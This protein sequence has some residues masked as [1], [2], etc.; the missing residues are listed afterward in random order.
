[1]SRMAWALCLALAAHFVFL[2]IPTPTEQPFSAPKETSRRISIQFSP[3]E[4]VSRRVAKKV[5]AKKPAEPQVTRTP[6]IRK[7][8]KLKTSLTLGAPTKKIRVQNKKSMS[9]PHPTP[10]TFVETTKSRQKDHPENRAT[11]Q[12]ETVSAAI[13]AKNIVQKDVKTGA[14]EKTPTPKIQMP[15]IPTETRPETAADNVVVPPAGTFEQAPK[16]T[17]IENPI[18]QASIPSEN[19]RI[20]AMQHPVYPRAARRQGREGI[21]QIRVEVLPDGTLGKLEIHVSSGSH[22]LDHSAIEAVEQW[23]FKPAT[24]G[25]KTVAQTAVFPIRFTLK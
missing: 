9:M 1:M 2:K 23:R 22:D 20:A 21:V 4:P 17:K 15:E 5:P 10:L 11:K 18:L 7:P 25:G 3:A 16:H 14:L 19:I 13:S 6:V 8:E 24:Q 12:S